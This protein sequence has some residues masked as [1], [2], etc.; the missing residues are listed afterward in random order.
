MDELIKS[1]REDA[2]WAEWNG[3]EVPL[4][5]PAHLKQA[6]DVIT[7]L[8]NL[9]ADMSKIN[10]DAIEKYLTLW[11]KQQRWIPV[12]ERLPEKNEDVLC[13]TSENEMFIATYMGVMG[14]DFVWDDGEGS[15]WLGDIT[16]WMKRPEPPK[17]E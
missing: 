5:L 2:E 16:H 13:F 8:C 14:G 4:M 17:E 11:E 9:C 12:T 6:A 10:S 3:W 7:E 1:L 15:A